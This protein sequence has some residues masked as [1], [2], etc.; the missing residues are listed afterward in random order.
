MKYYFYKPGDYRFIDV[1]GDREISYEDQV[2][3]GSA[4]PSL[5][6]GVVSEFQ[7]KNIDVN[8]SMSFQLGRHLMNVVRVRSLGGFGASEYPTI[9]LD[10][11]E[12][13]FWGKPE[14]KADFPKW[15]YDWDTYLWGGFHVHQV[16]Q[17]NWLK[18]KTLSIGYTLPKGWMQRCGLGELR[19]F[20]SGE[21]VLTWANYSGLDPEVVDIRTGIDEGFAYPMARKWT[22]GLTLK[23]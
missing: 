12:I 4:L 7:W 19:F 11:R 8:L 13:S 2:Y 10:L 23:F 9:V 5:S 22:L 21:N 17:V 16:E 6:G 14:D 1:N 15:Q 20:V 18:L 3:C